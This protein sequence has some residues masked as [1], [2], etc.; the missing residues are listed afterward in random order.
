MLTGV[1]L[2]G[3]L[4]R[5]EQLLQDVKVGRDKSVVMKSLNEEQISPLD[6]LKTEDLICQC[7]TVTKGTIFKSISVHQLTNLEEIKT[8]RGRNGLR[9]L[10]RACSCLLP[11]L[12]KSANGSTGHVLL[13]HKCRKTDHFSYI[14]NQHPLNEEQV[15][16]Q[17]D[18]MTDN[19]C[20]KCR[21]AIPY[22]LEQFQDLFVKTAHQIMSPY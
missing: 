8:D 22:Y 19:G 10:S 4:E 20:D 16:R 15:R 6:S 13:V 18:W 5:A 14:K 9:R 3:Q 11:C 21:A 7:H 12:I 2:V 17:F 1:V